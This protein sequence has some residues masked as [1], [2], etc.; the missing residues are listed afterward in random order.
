MAAGVTAGTKVL[1][2]AFTFTAIPSSIMRI[3]GVPVLVEMAPDFC[4]DLVALEKQVVAHPDARV[5]LLSHMRGRMVDMDRL[6]E[7]SVL[8]V[9]Y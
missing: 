1:T 4:M 8:P 3:G 2:N 9:S 5:L 7:I 6:Q